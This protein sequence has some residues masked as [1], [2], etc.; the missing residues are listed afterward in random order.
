[1]RLSTIALVGALII[2]A[3]C[4]ADSADRSEATPRAPS[5]DAH[6]AGSAGITVSIPPGWHAATPDDGNVVDPATRLVV[7]S[8]PITAKDSDCPIAAYAFDAKAVALVVVER[9]ARQAALPERPSEFST[10]ELAVQPPPAIE[11]FDGP[12]GS[13][14]FTE[15]GRSL[16]AYLLVGRD[17]PA[18]AVD[19]A[20]AVLGRM[21]V[22]RE[23]SDRQLARNGVSVTVPPG[24]D[25]R[26]LYRDASGS[27]G[28]IYQVA[29]F[30]LPANEGFEPPTELPPGQEDAIKAMKDGDA[31]IMI[32]ADA[33]TGR[34]APTPI[35]FAD[36]K[37]VPAARAPR[38]HR[39]AAN[40]F[41][42]GD[43]CLEI[44][45]DFGGNA[46]A[47]L[48]RPVSDVLASVSVD[49]GGAQSQA[50]APDAGTRGCPR[51]NWP[52]PW[53]KCAEA[54][55]VGRVVDRAGYQVVGETGSALIAEG[56]GAEF[57][58]WTT[59]VRRPLA[60]AADGG[61]WRHLGSSGGRAIYG[62][63]DLSR[64][65]QAQGFTFWLRAG[66]YAT[67]RLPT[68]NELGPLVEAS[69]TIEPPRQ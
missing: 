45:V 67:S 29:N 32:A 17:A 61:H 12:G 53:T 33:A 30:E 52:G 62:D 20:R 15:S 16:G 3:A 28:V 23:R 35:T 65:W 13:V 8:S 24:W 21:Q 36:L 44:Q 41:C 56:S 1:M 6:V 64:L 63:E 22:L 38:G 54:R 25:G 7:A 47:D 42:F 31:L 48:D 40:S 37:P 19:Q 10:R 68:L 5:A 14:Q 66:P 60:D 34:P 39:L 57:Y 49:T 69:A 46:S 2:S 9:N 50:T 27:L 51:P 26:M 55:W 18:D 43:R 59:Q 4:G 11:C 58:I